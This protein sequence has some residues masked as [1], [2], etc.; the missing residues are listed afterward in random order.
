MRPGLFCVCVLIVATLCF[1]APAARA[2]SDTLTIDAR[3]I[4][5]SNEAK[6]DS[7]LKP[8]GPRLSEK[9]KNS[10]FKWDHYYECTAQKPFKL[11]LHEAKRVTMSKRC[12]I[13]VTNQGGSQITMKLYGNGQLVNTVTQALP[14][15][16]FL[17][18]GGE[19]ENST[20]WFVA[21]RQAD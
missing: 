15:G 16:E 13:E 12:E 11:E 9:L 20:G 21:I 5:A 14:R 4:W 10:P 17:L 19:A 8:V 2:A 3:L 18:V 6:T 7:K 1:P